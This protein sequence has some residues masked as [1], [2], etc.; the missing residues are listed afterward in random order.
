MSNGQASPWE[1]VVAGTAAAILADVMVYP[2]DVYDSHF[3]PVQ[4]LYC[5]ICTDS[6]V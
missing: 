4:L 2:L 6:S 3:P 1:S 5:S